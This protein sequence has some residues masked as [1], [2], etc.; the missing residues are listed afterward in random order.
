[1]KKI[2]IYS[3]VENSQLTDVSYELLTKASELKVFAKNLKDEEIEITS[4]SIAP[5]LDEKSIKN[6]YYSG[7]DNVILI[8]N[9]DFS[10][11][12]QVLFLNAFLNFY[13]KNKFDYILFPATPTGR[14]L[15]PRITTSLNTGLVA[16]CT[17]IDFILKDN[18][19]KLAATR[20]TFGAELMATILSKRTPE[21]ATVRPKTFAAKFDTSRE[22]K[23]IEYSCPAS[24][25]IGLRPVGSTK[26][27]SD[28]FDFNNS[29]VILAAGFG[30]YDGRDNEYIEKLKKLADILGADFAA[31]RKLVDFGA[32]SAKYQIGQTGQTV[33]PDIYIA[34]GISGAIQHIQ[35]MK[36]SKTI[37][38]V[39][40]DPNA[41]IFKYSDYKI[42]GDAKGLIDEMLF[43]VKD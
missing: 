30:L 38:A 9:K 42:V 39:N 34:F 12:N 25:S 10:Q 7:A 8:K 27:E 43:K 29:K 5:S 36:N 15:A 19:L 33:T 28:D 23:Y 24:Y 1:M 31:S 37:V 13:D 4:F 3:E 2:A 22:G 6:A 17:G 32:V 21:C 16:D 40:S 14:I 18:E 41:E 26:V 11:F 35:G 20:P